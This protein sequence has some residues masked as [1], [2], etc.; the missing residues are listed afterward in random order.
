MHS[1]IFRGHR[2]EM[3]VLSCCPRGVVIV[4]R[5]IP[6]LH[7]PPAASAGIYRLAAV[8]DHGLLKVIL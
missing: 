1:F 4:V 2:N 7:A 8:S 6:N 5:G 3:A